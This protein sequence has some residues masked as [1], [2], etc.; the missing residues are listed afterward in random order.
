MIKKFFKWY[1]VPKNFRNYTCSI[2]I[3]TYL[4]S[5]WISG[6]DLKPYRNELTGLFSVLIMWLW[7]YAFW[8]SDEVESLEK[9]NRELKKEI[10]KIKDYMYRHES[11]I[12]GLKVDTFYLKQFVD[13][14]CVKAIEIHN[15]A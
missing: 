13:E 15:K 7:L 6:V 3:L 8:T 4:A 12:S 10:K 9:E 1:F 2:V 11:D 5:L 14:E